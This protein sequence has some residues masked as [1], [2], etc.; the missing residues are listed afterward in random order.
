MVYRNNAGRLGSG[1]ISVCLETRWLGQKSGFYVPERP[2]SGKT[3]HDLSIWSFQKNRF[4][5]CD[6]IFHM[7]GRGVA[8][9]RPSAHS[10]LAGRAHITFTPPNRHHDGKPPRPQAPPKHQ[11]I[12]R[13]LPTQRVRVHAPRPA[14][15]TLFCLE[16]LFLFRS[17]S[18][19][20]RTLLCKSRIEDLHHAQIVKFVSFTGAFTGKCVVK[21][22][23]ETCETV[24][25]IPKETCQNATKFDLP[26]KTACFC[27]IKETSKDAQVCDPGMCKFVEYFHVFPTS[28]LRRRK[29][30]AVPERDLQ[31]MDRVK[32]ALRHGLSNT[33]G[34]M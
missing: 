27:G 5:I 6:Y 28:C 22:V 13:N 15:C 17:L 26:Y 2:C 14:N 12:N 1:F 21:S 33:R 16:V 3:K 8:V 24:H 34:R 20:P 30:P 18:T 31:K 7:R 11:Q 9:A 25:S 4:S 10:A 23:K 32:I 19:D 29:G